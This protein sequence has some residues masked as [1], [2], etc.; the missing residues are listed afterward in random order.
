MNL[1]RYMI[2]SGVLCLLCYLLAGLSHAPIFGLLGCALCGFTVGIMWPGSISISS[3]T[4][5]LG[6]TAMFAFLALAG[7]LGGSIGP[8]IIGAISQHAGDN[9]QTGILAASCF[10]VILIL[11]VLYL[12]KKEGKY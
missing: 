3:K 6:G 7:D 1:K 10:P 11:C 4:L 2:V 12:I 5:P 8:G 9:L